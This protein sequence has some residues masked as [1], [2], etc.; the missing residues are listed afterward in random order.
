MILLIFI[1]R[2]NFCLNVNFFLLLA[3]GALP[4]GKSTPNLNTENSDNENR[5]TDSGNRGDQTDGMYNKR[6][7]AYK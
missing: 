5:E 7:E 3:N 6:A 4:R 1:I 2:L